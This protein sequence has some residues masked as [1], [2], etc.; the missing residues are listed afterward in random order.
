M[1]F[2]TIWTLPACTLGEKLRRT[3]DWAANMFGS[4]LPQ[5]V[6]YFVTMQEVVKATSY[7]KVGGDTDIMAIPLCEVLR[8]LETPKSRS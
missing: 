3:R 4:K 5:R 6:K 1:K 2:W 8:N 7:E